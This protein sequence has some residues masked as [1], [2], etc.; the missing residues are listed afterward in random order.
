MWCN[1]KP[2]LLRRICYLPSLKNSN[3]F[4]EYIQHFLL[5]FAAMA[6]DVHS[7]PK[8]SFCAILVAP[9]RQNDFLETS[10]S[11]K[12]LGKCS[13]WKI[14]LIK[15]FLWEK[16][17]IVSV[18]KA[19]GAKPQPLFFNKIFTFFYQNRF[20]IRRSHWHFY[21]DSSFQMRSDFADVLD[22]HSL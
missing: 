20:C 22:S 11:H 21:V 7:L 10:E 1:W 12:K 15:F 2:I 18:I 17:F 3:V 6:T 4:L 14:V 9:R 5:S 13:P 16:L 8:C 19:S